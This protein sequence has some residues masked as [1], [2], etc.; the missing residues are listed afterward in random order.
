METELR[1][2]NSR[3]ALHSTPTPQVEFHFL[4]TVLNSIYTPLGVHG[5]PCLKFH[6]WISMSGVPLMDA[7]VCT[8]VVEFQGGLPCLKF[9]VWI[10]M[11]GMDASAQD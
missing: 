7:S 3:L 10:S 11:S 4:S 1:Y 6:V 2:W 5:V 9:H 8:R